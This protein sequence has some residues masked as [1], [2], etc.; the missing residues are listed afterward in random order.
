MAKLIDKPLT[1]FSFL[2]NSFFV[3][4]SQRTGE[5]VVVHRWAVLPLSPE[6]RNLDRVDNFEYSLLPVQPV[7]EVPEVLRLEEQLL[8]ELPEMNVGARPRGRP[9]SAN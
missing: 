4:L 3:I 6:S 8:D 1:S 2:H 9:F 7:D 5:L